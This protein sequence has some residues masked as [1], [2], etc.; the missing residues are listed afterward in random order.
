MERPADDGAAILTVRFGNSLARRRKDSLGMK[1]S[2][3]TNCTKGLTLFLRITSK[4][5][6]YY[7]CY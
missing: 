1:S 2:S 3:P 5:C 7:R 6:V 4:Y